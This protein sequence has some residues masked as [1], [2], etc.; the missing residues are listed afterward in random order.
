M[1][2]PYFLYFNLNFE[3]GQTLKLTKFISVELIKSQEYV[4]HV[5]NT[6]FGQLIA[7]TEYGKYNI[8]N[9]FL[10]DTDTFIQ[11]MPA[12]AAYIWTFIV[13]NQEFGFYVSQQETL[14]YLSDA[15]DKTCRRKFALSFSEH[16]QNTILAQRQ[17]PHILQMLDSYC[18]GN[19]RFTTQT[20]K[21][22]MSEILRRLI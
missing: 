8:Q 5:K 4:D 22:I 7:E 18:Q 16:D 2:N 17:N 9:E 14:W 12:G 13:K 20:V 15:V 10:L 1:T 11:T 6:K 19:L 21:N 3:K